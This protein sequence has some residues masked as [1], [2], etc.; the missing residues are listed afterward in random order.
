VIAPVASDSS[1]AQLDLRFRELELRPPK[2]IADKYDT[3]RLHVVEA[4]EINA[5]PEVKA[6]HWVLL[7]SLPVT[8]VEQAHEILTYYSYR[9]L[10]ERFHYVLKSGCQLEGSQ[11]RERA[12]LERLLAMYSIVASRL[13]L[14]TYQARPL[15]ESVPNITAGGALD[16]SA[17]WLFGS[18][19]RRRAGRQSAVARLDALAGR[20]HTFHCFV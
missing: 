15:A 9:W 17:G 4:R 13:L 18:Q 16:R 5:P 20:D 14:L 8:S 6:V 7:T 11:L 19:A 3:F 10:I 1:R 2:N 12:S